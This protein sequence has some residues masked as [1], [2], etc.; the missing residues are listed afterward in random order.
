MSERRCGSCRCVRIM[1]GYATCPWKHADDN[2][3]TP[4]MKCRIP[5]SR[6]KH[7]RESPEKFK[8]FID[9]FAPFESLLRDSDRC[10]HGDGKSPLNCKLTGKRCTPRV[11]DPDK[12]LASCMFTVV[13]PQFKGI[14]YEVKKGKFVQVLEECEP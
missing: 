5:D 7:F 11:P 13:C 12:K 10:I 4:G 6:F 8:E 2:H 1:Y 3:V 14:L 9:K